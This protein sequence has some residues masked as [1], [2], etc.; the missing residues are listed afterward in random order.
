MRESMVGVMLRMLARRAFRD[1]ERVVLNLKGV[2]RMEGIWRAVDEGDEGGT[3]RN[4]GRDGEGP[5]GRGS[6]W[7][8]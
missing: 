1:S 5:G 8:E 7:W 4:E 2:R 6:R 3:R